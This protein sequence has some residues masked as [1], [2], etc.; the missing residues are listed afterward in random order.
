MHQDKPSMAAPALIGG[1]FLGITSALPLLNL[2]NCACCILVIGGGFIASYLY[3]KDYPDT[4][5]PLSYGDGALLG[6]LTG[7][8]GGLV[9]SVVQVPLELFH[10]QL[11]AAAGIAQLE[12]ALSDPNIPPELREILLELFAKGGLTAATLAISVVMNLVI[13][14]IFAIVGAIIGV[15]VF[16]KRPGSTAFGPPTNQ[17]GHPEVQPGPPPAP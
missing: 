17:T 4:L 10:L 2:F 3:L 7:V 16:Q 8:I 1:V 13:G 6:L 11:G 15:A 14:V 12:E 5:P 9:W